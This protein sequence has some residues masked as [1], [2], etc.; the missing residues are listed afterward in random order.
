MQFAASMSPLEISISL[1]SSQEFRSACFF[2]DLYPKVL[3]HIE[4]LVIKGV[5]SKKRT[6]IF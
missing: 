4:Q 6:W 2:E 3:T 1:G 5:L